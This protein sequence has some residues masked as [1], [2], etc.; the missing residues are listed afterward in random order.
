[1]SRILRCFARAAGL[2]AFLAVPRSAPAQGVAFQL[3]RLFNDGGWTS[4]G[5]SWARPVLG[6]VSLALGGTMLRGDGLAS[7]RLWGASG[8]VSIFRGGR[9]GAYAVGAVAAGL[10]TGGAETWWRSWSAGVGY[11]LLPLRFLSLGV[12]GRYRE[13][14]PRARSGVELSFRIGASLGGASA[15]PPLTDVPLATAASGSTANSSLT[16]S[17]AQRLLDGVI[18]TA[19]SMIGVRYRF[20]GT[21]EDGRGFDCSGLIQYAY[22]RHGIQLPR[23]SGQQA[24]EG[25]AVDRTL[26]ALQ[27]GDLLTFSSSGRGVTHVGMYIGGGRFIHSASTGVQTST[28]SAN[29]PYGK[30]WY[31][32]WVGVRRIVGTDG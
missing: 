7:A 32:R 31:Q 30:W 11:E 14:G 16:R 2:T 6:P 23:T 29:D 10:G 3:G 17:D 13:F 4:Y 19:D 12:E 24:A 21:G 5:V 27:P 8:E 1:V 22:A 18:A 15:R 25:R 28:L 26:D 9:P 20:G